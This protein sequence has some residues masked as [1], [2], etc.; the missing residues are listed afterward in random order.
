MRDNEGRCLARDIRRDP[1]H[2]FMGML[3]IRLG[4]WGTLFHIIPL[5]AEAQR[6]EEMGLSA[7]RFELKH[8]D[9]HPFPVGPEFHVL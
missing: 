2:T 5:S 1:A 6:A 4:A 3:G 9:S 8:W 7:C